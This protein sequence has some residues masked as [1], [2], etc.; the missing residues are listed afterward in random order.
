MKCREWD[1]TIRN[2]MGLE[3]VFLD[4]AHGNHEDCLLCI[5]P[6][7]HEEWSQELISLNYLIQNVGDFTLWN[8]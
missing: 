4:V 3:D 5:I 8:Y 7:M 1:R 6:G 2:S